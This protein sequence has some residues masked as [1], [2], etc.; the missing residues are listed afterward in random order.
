MLSAVIVYL[1][2]WRIANKRRALQNQISKRK[3][4]TGQKLRI[5]EIIAHFDV[6]DGDSRNN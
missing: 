5:C 4:T 6:I 3:L 2:R 1:T